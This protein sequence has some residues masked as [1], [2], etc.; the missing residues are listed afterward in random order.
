MGS[1]A[2]RRFTRRKSA[3]EIPYL[4]EMPARESVRDTLC[5]IGQTIHARTAIFDKRT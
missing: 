4:R 5:E 2:H 1:E 3:K